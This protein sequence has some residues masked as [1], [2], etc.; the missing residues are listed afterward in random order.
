MN[1][2]KQ[3]RFYGQL[4]FSI[5]LLVCSCINTAQAQYFPSKIYPKDYFSNPIGIPIQLSGNFGEVRNEHFH[6]GLDIRTGRKENLPIYASASGYISRI[7]IERYGYGRAIYIKH[8]NGYTTL[9]AHLNNF[10]DTLHNYVKTKQYTEQKWEQDFEFAPNQFPVVKG[11]FIAFSGNTGGSR[12]AHLHFEIRNEQ[13]DNVNPLLFNLNIE[14]S[15]PPVIENFFVYDRRVSTYRISPTEI[16][17]V[18]N[19]DGYAT[20]DSIIYVSSSTISF[21]IAAQDVTNTSPF[22]FGIYQA[23]VWADSV[24]AFAFRLNDFS[25]NDS[26]YVNGCID[27]VVTHNKGATIQHLSKLPGNLLHIFSANTGNGIIALKDTTVKQIEIIIKDVAGNASTLFLRVQKNDSLAAVQH[28]FNEEVFVPNAAVQY[29]KQD[30]QLYFNEAAFYDTIPL[31]L[32]VSNGFSKT[33]VSKEF[34][35]SPQMPVHNSYVVKLPLTETIDDSLKNKV[36]VLLKNK[37]FAQAK[38][39]DWN[40]NMAS[41]SFD[42]LGTICLVLD[43]VPPTIQPVGWKDNFTF[44]NQTQLVVQVKDAISD[45]KK[46]TA[47]LDSQW[48]LFSRKNDLF[49]CD[50]DEH[51]GLGK[52]QLTI[53]AE[54]IVGNITKKTY[55]FTK[56]PPKANKNKKK[57][58]VKR[59]KKKQSSAKKRKK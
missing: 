44:N 15:M 13:G 32:T 47:I 35:L 53:L 14:D 45:I 31:N 7:K 30:I 5:A 40:N 37:S 16:S 56:E 25:Y 54:D 6:M 51:C 8:P 2:W 3:L 24:M 49:I 19:K 36:V 43:T 42:R 4:V 48:V 34:L 50:F 52:H 18:K 29:N 1:P 38:I 26:R 20:K 22:K 55:F 59:K 39:P 27:Y 33:A 41:T 11:Q 57:M 46:Y 12:G 28:Q 10:Y 21:G 17:I 23:E 9:Y 58:L